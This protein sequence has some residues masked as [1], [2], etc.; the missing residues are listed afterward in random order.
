MNE[1]ALDRYD[2]TYEQEYAPRAVEKKI[3]VKSMNKFGSVDEDFADSIVKWT[4]IIRKSFAEN[5]V[6]EVISTRRA[7][8]I[9][10]AFAMFGNKQ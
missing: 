7:I 4:E 9:C 3:L 5:A 8:N 10:K 1:A 6:D 2:F